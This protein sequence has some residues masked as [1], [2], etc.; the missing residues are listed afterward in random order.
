MYIQG[1]HFTY[2]LYIKHH[3][4]QVNFNMD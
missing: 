3:S 1:L 4:N 2:I